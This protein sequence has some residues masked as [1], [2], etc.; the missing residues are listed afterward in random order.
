MTPHDVPLDILI[1]PEGVTRAPKRPKPKGILWEDLSQ[2][3]IS[4]IPILMKLADKKS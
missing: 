2:E 3:K 1:T 4:E